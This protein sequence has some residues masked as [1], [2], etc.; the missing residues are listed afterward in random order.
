MFI[1]QPSVPVPVKMEGP[2]QLPTLALV[3]RGGWECSVKQVHTYIW[4]ILGHSH[5]VECMV[6]ID[7]IAM[8]TGVYSMILVS[9]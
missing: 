3:M 6:A 7:L 5:G 8:V 1:V 9:H 4:T 2:V